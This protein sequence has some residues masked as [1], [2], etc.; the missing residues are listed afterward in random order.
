MPLFLHPQVQQHKN[1]K[2]NGKT[3]NLAPEIHII[4][5]LALNIPCLGNSQGDQ[6]ISHI[7]VHL[8]LEI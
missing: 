6:L 7:L 8:L 5:L 3:E 2:H 1:D 4:E